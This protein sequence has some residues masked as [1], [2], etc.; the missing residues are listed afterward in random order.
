MTVNDGKRHGLTVAGF[1]PDCYIKVR[2]AYRGVLPSSG[3]AP[4]F[5]GRTLEKMSGDKKKTPKGGNVK[6]TVIKGV[7]MTEAEAEVMKKEAE[8][9]HLSEGAW[10]RMK[11]FDSDHEYIPFE[12]RSAFGRYLYEIGKI[13]TNINTVCRNCQMHKSVDAYDV[14][15]LQ[16]S[17]DALKGYLTMIYETVKGAYGHGSDKTTED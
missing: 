5:V 6:R 1:W 14:R 3:R 13:G 8:K 7:R 17:V 15:R 10:A 12:I 4:F 11:L 16:D 2:K 9:E